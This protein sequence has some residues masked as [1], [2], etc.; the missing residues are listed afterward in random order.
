MLT[1]LIIQN[2]KNLDDVEIELDKSVVF[3]GPNNSGKTTALQAIALWNV[4]LNAWNVRWKGK[5]STGK[6]PGVTINRRDVITIPVPVANL[7]WRGL[8]TRN[9]RS[10]EGKT[11]TKNILIN[12]IVEGIT[13]GD[14]WECGLEFDYAN[15][16]SFYCRP[17]RIEED[18][19]SR[20]SVPGQVSNLRVA[21]LPPMSGL[22]ASEPKMEAG[23]INVL[24]GEGQ[25]AQVLRNL[26]YQIYDDKDTDLWKNLTGHMNELFGVHIL[27]PEFII[28]RGEISMSYKDAKIE[29]DISSSGRGFQQT[30]LLIAYLY[31]NPKTVLLL[32]EPDAHLEILRQRQIYNT[33]MEVSEKTGS[34]IIIASHSEVILREAANVIAFLGKKPHRINNKNQLLKSLREIP[35]DEYYLAEQTGWILYLEG[36]TDLAILK[37]FATIIGHEAEKCLDLAFVKYTGDKDHNVNHHFYGL[38]EAKNDLLGI[39]IYDN[40]GKDLKKHD[41][42][43]QLMWRKNEIEN[44][45][46]TKTTLLDYARNDHSTHHDLLDYPE[47]QRRVTAM[48][49]SIKETNEYSQRF[50]DKDIWSPDLKASEDVLKPLFKEYFKK[51]S[52]YNIMDKSD[53][54]ILS[55]FVPKEDI[56]PEVIE[57]LDAIV[58][59]A[60]RAAQL[61]S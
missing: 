7:L 12:I 32:D 46:C 43:V 6:R 22:M 8:H 28:E 54:H 15:P 4:G 53:Y 33:L 34:Q 36:S 51:L 21:F 31:K 18:G 2:F 37:A 29:L 47:I 55:R 17:L 49:E 39:G 13:N 59:T 14:K 10:I 60:K 9:V 1:K 30:L 25:T 45:L 26:C 50:K 44:Y 27:P 23:R 52:L 61:S 24:I 16:E 42:L 58:E 48:E 41:N 35:Y 40:L 19:T 20:M 38:C 3:V 56:D 11:D 5:K 57:K